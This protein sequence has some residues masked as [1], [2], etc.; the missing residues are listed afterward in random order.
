MASHDDEGGKRPVVID[1]HRLD[2]LPRIPHPPWVTVR[3]AVWVVVAVVALLSSYF[4]LAPYEQGVVLRFG[5]HVR[6][7]GSG[8]HLKWP[9]GIETVYRVET[10]KQHKVEFGFRTKE[11]GQRTVYQK[12]GFDEESLMLTGDLNIA[13]VEWV[14]QYRIVDPYRYLFALR[15]VPETI[16]VVAEAEMRGA[17]GDMGFD[18]VIKTKRPEIEEQVRQHLNE[19]LGRYGA[20]VDIKLVQLQDVHPPDPVK[21]SFEEVNRALQ[22]MER[23]INEALQERN[24]ILFRVE[25]EAKQRVSE[26]EG[27]KTERINQAEGDAKR[28]SLLLAQYRKAPAVTRQRLYLEAMEEVLPKTG[29]IL[30]VDEAVKG[31][32][33]VLDLD[34][35]RKAAPAAQP[36]QP[37]PEPR[38]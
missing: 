10:E 13:D 9:F 11:P 3:R 12:E 4:Q 28:F 7:V 35:M 31:L 14:V 38:R 29:R 34:S 19:I 33:P 27:T 21:D 37:P 2:H 22:E 30:V 18:E 16:R 15:D 6:T 20:G 24:K 8:P 5:R 36:A 23:S 17:V 1:I 25:G 32:L 26:A